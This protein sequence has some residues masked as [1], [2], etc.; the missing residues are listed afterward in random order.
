MFCHMIVNGSDHADVGLQIFMYLHDCF[1]G[2]FFLHQCFVAVVA[3]FNI[4]IVSNYDILNKKNFG[5][6]QRT[7]RKDNG[8]T[9]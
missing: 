9:F 2:S 3:Q 8:S 4:L 6:C 5:S 7:P 1:S